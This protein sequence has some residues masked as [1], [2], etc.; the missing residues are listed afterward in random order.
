MHKSKIGA[1]FFCVA[2]LGAAP[3][4]GGQED[5][6]ASFVVE[7]CAES[8]FA[9]EDADQQVLERA[10]ADLQSSGYSGLARHL[11]ALN[12][13][14]ARAPSCYPQIERRDGQTIVR[15]SDPSEFLAVSL[16]LAAAPGA[17]Q[18]VMRPNTYA[19]AALYLASNAVEMRQFDAALSYLDRGLALQPH[20]QFLMLER[21]SALMG[22]RRMQDAEAALRAALGDPALSLTLDRARFLRNHGVVLI[23]LG[24]LDEAEA[25]LSESIR[26]EPN[27]PGARNEL[28]YIA[29]LREG[30]RQR[31][32]ELQAPASMPQ[33]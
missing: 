2:F 4:A 33:K 17:G 27:N 15:A 12:A 20:N 30:A 10:M 13:V 31:E 21:V 32:V 6:A 7:R 29:Q 11:D 25:A 24:R 8:D 9:S 18:I 3:I 19:D 23:E 26:L 1:V 28:Q 22:L 16:V 14:L 5:Q